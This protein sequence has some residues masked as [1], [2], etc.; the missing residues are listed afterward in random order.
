MSPTEMAG[1][2]DRLVAANEMVNG[3]HARLMITRGLKYTPYQSPKLNV[4]PPTI[5][6]I[7]EYK[8]KPGGQMTGP[9][10]ISLATAHVRRGYADSQDQ[11]LNSHSKI[12]C[13]TACI[14]AI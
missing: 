10:P 6:C 8:E 11:K 2:L 14:A 7:A 3:V 12:N 4:G 9:S 5:C 13:I 1:E